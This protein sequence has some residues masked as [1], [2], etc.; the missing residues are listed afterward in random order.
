ML[1]FKTNKENIGKEVITE[2]IFTE[3]TGFKPI[4][5]DLERCNCEYA[6]ES[7]HWQCG[8]NIALN[9]PVFMVGT[10]L[11]DPFPKKE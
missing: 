9:K 6:G 7:G 5:D 11:T 8:W 10:G 4:K 1:T 3:A 2:E